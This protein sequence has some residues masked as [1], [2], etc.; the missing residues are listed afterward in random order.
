M[1]LKGVK[2]EVEEQPVVTAHM[3]AMSRL[4]DHMYHLFCI[5]TPLQQ[6]QALSYSNVEASSPLFFNINNLGKAND[7]ST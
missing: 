5:E 7:S 1:R 2:E 3:A 6:R 4:L